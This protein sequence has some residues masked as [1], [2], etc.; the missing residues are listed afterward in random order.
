MSEILRVAIATTEGPSEIQRLTP[1]DPDVRSVVCLA[2][3][4]VSLPISKAYD[5]FV[6][7]PTGVVERAF[8]HSAFR[9]DVAEPV[10]DGLSWQLPVF[11][12]HA[13][14]D[15]GRL[16]M[17]GKTGRDVVW[18]TGEVDRDL[19]VLPVAHCLAKLDHSRAFFA[20]CLAAGGNVAIFLP[21]GNAREI[22]ACWPKRN[23]LDPARVRIVPVTSV[24]E[25][26]KGIGIAPQARKGRHVFMRMRTAWRRLHGYVLLFFVVAGLAGWALSLVFRQG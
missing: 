7:N 25:V 5:A 21:Q 12:A 20:E 24:A 19:Q 17:S 15:S 26:L 9:L 13:L 8:G 14:L 16:S 22:G 6:R 4:A 1:E 23:G 2:G 10:G 18:L 11:V 3:K